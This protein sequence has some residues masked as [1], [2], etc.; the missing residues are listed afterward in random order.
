[1]LHEVN[2]ATMQ[3]FIDNYLAKGTINL[4]YIKLLTDVLLILE[5]S[6]S[7]V[8]QEITKELSISYGL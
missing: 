6:L 7:G 4:S 8:H 2:G 3:E 5:G 1:M